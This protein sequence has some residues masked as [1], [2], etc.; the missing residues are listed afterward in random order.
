LS[1]YRYN[2]STND[3]AGWATDASKNSDKPGEATKL[4]LSSRFGFPGPQEASD[5]GYVLKGNPRVKI[6]DEG[7]FD[8]QL[9]IDTSQYGRTFQDRYGQL[10]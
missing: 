3:F 8:F 6:F 2:I 5:R 4:D 1:C 10:W 7:D 9:A